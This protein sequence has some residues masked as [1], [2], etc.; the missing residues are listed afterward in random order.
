MAISGGDIITVTRER[1][2]KGTII[3]EDGKIVGL[4]Q[5]LEI[6]DGAERIDATGKTITPGFVSISMTGVGT[7]GGQSSGKL[8]DQLNPFDRNIQ[9]ALGV[10]ITSGCVQVPRGGGFGRRRAPESGFDETD[11]F[12]VLI[13]MNA[14]LRIG[15]ATRLKLSVNRRHFARAAIFPFCL[16]NQL[17]R[18]S[19]H[20]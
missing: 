7:A 14:R 3:I 6:P 8:A 16:R 5:N 17:P 10:G 20:Q 12:P 2:R 1:I 11:R 15:S 4:G 13:R 9:L 19:H 18:L